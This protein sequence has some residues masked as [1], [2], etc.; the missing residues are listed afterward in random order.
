MPIIKTKSSGFTNV[1]F[2]R[3]ELTKTLIK[4]Y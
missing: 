3:I 4:Y 1:L 2:D